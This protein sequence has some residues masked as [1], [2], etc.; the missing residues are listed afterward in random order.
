MDEKTPSRERV[1][2]AIVAAAGDTGLDRG[3]LQKSVFLVGQEFDEK[4]PSDFYQFAPYMYGPFTQDVYSD[5]ERLSDGRMVE[6]L[7]GK[8][9]RVAYR[10]AP[11]ASAGLG[12]LPD[13]LEA[14]VG[15][16]VEWVKSMTFNELVRAIYYLYPEQQRASVFD[17]YSDE[18]AQ[19]ESL[20]VRCGYST[21][22]ISATVTL[23]S[24]DE[25]GSDA[26]RWVVGR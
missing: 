22:P 13:D 20:Y 10:L 9:G 6:T 26:I 4:L 11:D 3:Q 12:S 21:K 16:I 25:V 8:R 14:G 7:T 24:H 18:K 2:I 5:V 23:V 19:E 15:R 1:L 17:D